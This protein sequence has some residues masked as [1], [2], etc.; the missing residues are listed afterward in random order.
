MK[1]SSAFDVKIRERAERGRVGVAT[2]DDR[3]EAGEERACVL[4]VDDE[5]EI[6]RSVAELL[7]RDYRVLVANS[8]AEGLALLEHNAVSVILTDQRMPNGSGAELLA[9]SLDV[10]PEVTRILFT[11]YSDISAVIEAVNKGQIYY[12][13]TKPWKPEELRAV[14]SRGLERYRL[15]S[16]NRQ[17]L[18]ELTRANEILE[19]RVRE[20]TQR[21]KRQN[22]ALR[23]ARQRIEA[24]SRKDALT[25]LAN[26]GWLDETLA[27]EV[28]RSR[29]YG[30]RLS[31][32]MGD[33][34]HFKTVNDSFGHLVGD[35]VLQSTADVFRV[36]VR[37][38]D[39]AGRY[40]GE[41]FLIVL[42]NTGLAE[43]CALAERLRER[44]ERM[45][46]SFRPEPVTGSFGVAEWTSGESVGDVVHRAD[47]AL[48]EAK[49]RG[50]NRVSCDSRWEKQE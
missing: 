36:G 18:D 8:A 33:L 50:R 48:Y 1:L 17:L 21:L 40:G 3:S 39:L 20:R 46:V 44:V 9:V 13:L 49:E 28:E 43:A 6:T 34:D 32:I 14:L 15:V 2:E 26:R 23:E 41:E 19:E 5:A 10:A 4:V 27:L 42:P 30:P 47:K 7:K 11:G 12:Y 45:P 24:I 16:E 35:K 29:R 31:L 38:T 25:G 22:R 37:M